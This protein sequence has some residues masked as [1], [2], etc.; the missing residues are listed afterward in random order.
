MA[1]K[2]TL[3]KDLLRVE[4]RLKEVLQPVTPELVFVEDLRSRLDQEMINKVKTKKVRT[5][6]MVAGGIVGAVVMVITVIRS[7]MT[8]P[9][10][11]QSIGDRFKKRE[12]PAS[13]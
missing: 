9:S 6:L 11:V 5:G 13:I 7:I 1:R 8:W 10:V 4:S 2:E 12:Q 3:P